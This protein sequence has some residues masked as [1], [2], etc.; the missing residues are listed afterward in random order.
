MEDF[1]FYGILKIL[2][3]VNIIGK[4]M[5]MDHNSLYILAFH[6]YAFEIKLIE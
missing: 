6:C 3:L 2:V 5:Y 1:D 4:G